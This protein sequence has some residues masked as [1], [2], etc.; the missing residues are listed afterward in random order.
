MRKI[1]VLRYVTPLR[2]G[3]SLPAIVE[4]DDGFLYV[5]KFR[6]AGQGTKALIA[7]LI[8][9]ELARIAGF[10]IP[11]LVFADLDPAYG[12]SEPDE[13][14]QDLLKASAGLNLGLHYL[15]GAITYDPVAFAIDPLLASKIVWFDAFLMNVDRTPRN[16]NML[17]WKHECWLID[18]GASLYFH[19][20]WDNWE[21][22]ST[23][24]FIQIKDHVLLPFASRMIEADEWMRSIITKEAIDQVVSLIPG[25]WLKPEEDPEVYT[26]FLTNRL[27]Q[28]DVFLNQ[29]HASR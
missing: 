5:L 12:R 8:G 20:T 4:G 22:Q 10:K 24:P 28:A 9:G 19:H 3:G 17:V 21:E 14:I 23:K 1:S 29:I 25:D 27:L 11:E 2:E 26:K 7:E 13:E 6:G 16:T 15:S 18:H